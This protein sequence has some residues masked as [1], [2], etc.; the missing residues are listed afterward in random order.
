MVAPDVVSGADPKS[1]DRSE[2]SQ[3]NDETFT[4]AQVQ[5]MIDAAG[6]G[7][8]TKAD[9]EQQSGNVRSSLMRSQNEERAGW[10]TE[11][12]TFR[13]AIINVQTKDMDDGTRNAYEAELYKGRS[14]ELRTEL[15]Q[16]RQALE[17]AQQMG[18]YVQ[19]LVQG[20]GVDISDLDLT[21]VDTLSQTAVSAAA[22]RY[23]E[24]AS[25]LRQAQER[26]QELTESED[27][28]APPEAPEVVTTTGGTPDRAPTIDDLRKSVSEDR[29][30]DYTISE[31][32]L[33][34]MAERPDETGVDLNVVLDAIES[35][36]ANLK[37]ED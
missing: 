35:E 33:F 22:E 29:G 17:S 12:E 4:K 14:D 28:D 8:V 10:E 27:P 20:F 34:E 32:Q 23:Q 36:L 16:T 2:Q 37:E 25:E 24:T 15:L 26:I 6:E 30:L 9:V 19:G 18:S 31:E 21:N 5:E 7:T 11:R 13:D 1:D 3:A